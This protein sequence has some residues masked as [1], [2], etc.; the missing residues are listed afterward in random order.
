MHEQLVGVKA[1]KLLAIELAFFSVLAIMLIAFMFLHS[2]TFHFDKVTMNYYTNGKVDFTTDVTSLVRSM[3]MIVALSLFFGATAGAVVGFTC[4]PHFLAD[5]P[6]GRSEYEENVAKQGLVVISETTEGT[7]YQLTNL[8]R[9]F[10]RE[11]RFLEK[12]EEPL[13]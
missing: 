11:Y 1:K 10:L 7:T 6:S 2:Y 3:S 13:V 5:S 12:P 9:R 8:G 4:S